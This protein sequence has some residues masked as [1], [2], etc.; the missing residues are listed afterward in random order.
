MQSDPKELLERIGLTLPLIGLYDAPEPERFAPVVSPGTGGRVCIFAFY[1]QW[2]A[3]KTLHLTRE[4]FGCRGAGYW[5]WGTQFRTREAFVEFLVD[6][7]G[8]KANHRL[9]H[10][11]LDHNQ[12]YQPEY[13]NILIGPLRA[14]LRAYLKSVTFLVNP[15]QLS[16]LALGAQY[17]SAPSDP[18]PVIAPFGSGCM[19]LLPLFETIDEPQ[20]I[21]GATDIAMRHYLPPDLLAFTVTLPM[22]ER[23][24]TL[25]EGSFL[26]KPFLARLQ[27]ARQKTDQAL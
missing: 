13:P 16:A 18:L 3:G 9:M 1:K 17:H 6:D 14:D 2:L 8:L 4:R 12:P 10:L 27:S 23:L 11:W 22:F 7:E 24:C 19:Q 5:L 15:D 21:V 26:Y 20:A 25:D